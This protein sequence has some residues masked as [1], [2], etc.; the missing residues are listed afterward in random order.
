MPRRKTLSIKNQKLADE[1]IP[2]MA[3]YLGVLVA[4]R[5]SVVC[6]HWSSRM[7]LKCGWRSLP[8]ADFA[9]YAADLERA[10]LPRVAAGFPNS[11]TQPSVLPARI[12][13]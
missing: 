13:F 5:S 12:W 9:R 4:I 2:V 3:A 11:E 7:P 6:H 8:S 1:S 10:A